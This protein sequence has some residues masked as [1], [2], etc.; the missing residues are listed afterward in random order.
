MGRQSPESKEVQK[1]QETTNQCLIEDADK[2]LKPCD[3][4]QLGPVGTAVNVQLGFNNLEPIQLTLE[5]LSGSGP[6][7]VMQSDF[8]FILGQVKSEHKTA[9]NFYYLRFPEEKDSKTKVIVSPDL[10]RFDPKQKAEYRAAKAKKKAFSFWVRI[11][12]EKSKTG[13]LQ[14][15]F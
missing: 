12:T 1:A 13:P 8:P 10:E 3:I 7:I 14:S 9:Y 4:V 2:S 6:I 15:E 5:G 11:R